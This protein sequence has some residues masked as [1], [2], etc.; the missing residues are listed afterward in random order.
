MAFVDQFGVV[1]VS[2]GTAVITASLGGVEAQ[3]SMTV[4]SIGGFD[5]A[6]TPT[7]NANDVI[8]L[9]SDSYDDVPVEFF[10]GYWEPWQTTLSNDFVVSG[11]NMIHYTNF[12][13]VGNQFGTPTVNAT[14]YSNLHI[15]IYLPEV[16]SNL[17]F[18]ITIKDFGADM[19]DG[20]GDDTTQQVFFD[21]DDFEEGAWSTLEIPVTMTTRN[22]IGQIIY[23][24]INGS[25]LSE[26][27]IDNIYFYRGN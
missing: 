7:R 24:N 21:G 14:E 25:S 10:N 13:F 18:L 26:F 20:G 2:D 1:S 6:P 8:S 11:N 9:Y 22:N 27:F 16:P 5:V 4:T 23:E 17:D 15:N 12:N 3:G 19:L